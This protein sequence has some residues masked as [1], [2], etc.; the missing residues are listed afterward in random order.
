[1]NNDDPLLLRT[2]MSHQIFE[3]LINTYY[4]PLDVWYTRTIIDKVR[5][6]LSSDEHNPA[7]T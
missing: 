7:D 1:M 3:D 6:L 4:I 2:T 5:V